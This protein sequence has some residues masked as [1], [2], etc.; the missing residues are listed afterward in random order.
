M[1]TAPKT[2]TEHKVYKS[3]KRRNVGVE[4]GPKGQINY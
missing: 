2:L 1:Q 4:S 3:W